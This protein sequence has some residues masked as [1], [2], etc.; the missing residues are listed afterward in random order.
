MSTLVSLGYATTPN[1]A[2]HYS[3]GTNPRKIVCQSRDEALVLGN[4]LASDTGSVLFLTSGSKSMEPLIKGRAYV[5]VQTLPFDRIIKGELLVYLG[6][7]SAAN[8]QNPT[9]MLHRT[10][11]QDKG[12]WIMS[13][14]NNRWS[15]SWD[16][17]TKSTYIGTVTTILEFP[18]V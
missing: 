15:E 5:V 9:C 4:S 3:P 6:H 17:V 16:R 1:T 2:N 18:Q 13:G 14:D 11:L 7:P 8:M 12:G 10:V